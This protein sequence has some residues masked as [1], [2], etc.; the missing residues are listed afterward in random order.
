[1]LDYPL[2]YR[3]LLIKKIKGVTLK[4][5][6]A[7]EDK[8]TALLNYFL[9]PKK[10]EKR[11]LTFEELI[12]ANPSELNEYRS[13]INKQKKEWVRRRRLALQQGFYLPLNK[14][15]IKY[16]G[17]LL[18]YNF[19]ILII[20]LWKKYTMEKSSNN[21]SPTSQ[22]GNHKNSDGKQVKK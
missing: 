1:M 2:S 3:Q 22:K 17:A 13:E 7:H 8:S 15:S 5:I 9:V 6:K 12:K 20:P 10:T 19:P 21:S 11:S 4:K 14:Y 16:L 18:K